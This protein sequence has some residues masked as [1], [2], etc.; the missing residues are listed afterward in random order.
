M[1]ARILL[2]LCAVALPVHASAA[3]RAGDGA[4]PGD[5]GAPPPELEMHRQGAGEPDASGWTAAR[6]SAGRFSVSAPARFD[7]F[8]VRHKARDGTPETVHGIT[9]T[10]GAARFAAVC[11]LR[12]DGR[13][14]PDALARLGK[15]PGART[16]LAISVGGLAGVEVRASH[17]GNSALMRAL[18]AAD[19]LY[20]LTVEFPDGEAAAVLPLARRFLESFRAE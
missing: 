15:I 3:D 16:P 11:V 20:L 17:E 6:S 19:R 4:P 18:R 8:T 2:L 1:H 14:D 7:D 5:G 13:V 12:A 10:R 9:A